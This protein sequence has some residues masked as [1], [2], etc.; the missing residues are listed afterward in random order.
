MNQSEQSLG[1][2][3]RQAHVDLREDLGLLAE[4]LRPQNVVTLHVLQERLQQTQ[5]HILNHFRLEEQGGYLQ[6]VREAEPRL[7]REIDQLQAEHGQLIKDLQALLA[8]LEEEAEV[9]NTVRKKVQTW[10]KHV[11]H[12]ESRE[13]L[14]VEDAFTL[15]IGDKD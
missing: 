12:H 2:K 6:E 4:T 9:D 3:L 13:N 7:S 1:E 5:T 14:L 10:I 8:D 11:R 15:D